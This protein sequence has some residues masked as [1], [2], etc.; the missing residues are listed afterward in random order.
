MTNKNEEDCSAYKK[1]ITRR[2]AIAMDP[3]ISSRKEPPVLIKLHQ[4]A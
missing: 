4:Q 3:A 2:G 1:E